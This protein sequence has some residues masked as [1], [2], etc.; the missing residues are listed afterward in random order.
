MV[1]PPG[2]STRVLA[3][4]AFACLSGSACTG[5]ID[6]SSTS[7]PPAPEGG[8]S[9]GRPGAPGPNGTPGPNGA[10]GVT[11]K[12]VLG[13]AALRRL[14]ATQYRNAIG[15]LLGTSSA[16]AVKLEDDARLNG[17]TSIG[18]SVTSVSTRGT[19][20]FEQSADQVVSAALSDPARRSSLV[21]CEPGQAACLQQ[22][23]SRFGRRA[24]RRD[25]STEEVA[26]YVAL[27][28]RGATRAADPWAGLRWALTALLQSPH[29]L[30]RVELGR[31]DP[32]DPGRRLLTPFELA[33]RLAFFLTDR[34]P[35]DSLLEAAARDDLS[36]AG[37]EAQARRLL[38][39]PAAV[40]AVETFY[41]DYL[42]LGGLAELTRDAAFTATLKA[43]LRAETVQ[44]LR[45]LTFDEGRDFRSVFT[46]RATFLTPEL[47]RFYGLD[48]ATGRGEYPA[49]TVRQG[50]LMHGSLLALTAHDTTTSPTRR[51]KFL[52]ETVLCQSIPDPPPN[53]QTTL[54]GSDG[55]KTTTRQR[56]QAH[57]QDP[58][59]ATCH[60]LMDPIGLGLE[61]FDASGRYRTAEDGRPIDASGTL[62]G[63]AF[64]G[65]AGLAR[66]VSEHPGLAACFTNT[67]LR[68]AAG[69]LLVTPDEQGVAGDLER[70]FREAAHSVR[71]LLLEVVT[72]PGFR[73][74]RPSEG[75][76]N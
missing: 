66:A 58:A 34:P 69:A 50:L 4:V 68:Q 35:D 75:G 41:D 43:A 72:H 10:P 57:A 61:N 29:F 2:R 15:D 45:A 55:G 21:G 59:C 32:A 25:L 5:K 1:H 16:A 12:P 31:A 19:E 44:T 52:R 27:A 18:A 47:S 40:A 39:L 56:V 37:L 64:D 38:S 13:Q 46:S 26:R 42:D 53:V 76:M 23:V 63:V 20:L 11:G 36:P 14:T 70:R 6:P 22:F 49:A 54:P 7:A 8:S 24:W 3:C 28:Q 62:D 48:S 74:V 73:H 9:S 33:S 71:A 60:A 67:V 30:Y 17:L 51:G 65:P